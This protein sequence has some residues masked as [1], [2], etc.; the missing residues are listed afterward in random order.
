MKKSKFSSPFIE[1]VGNLKFKQNI[2][3]RRHSILAASE[4]PWEESSKTTK[5]TEIAELSEISH[6]STEWIHWTNVTQG[7]RRTETRIA[8][9]KSVIVARSWIAPELSS[10][11]M[12]ETEDDDDDFENR[13]HDMQKSVWCSEMVEHVSYYDMQLLLLVTG[14]V[15]TSFSME[16]QISIIQ[17]TWI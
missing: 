7:R 4:S 10:D 11:K 12:E 1:Q 6:S 2:F 14:D 9:S 8:E 3:V 13:R 15:L 17:Y 16:T 5:T